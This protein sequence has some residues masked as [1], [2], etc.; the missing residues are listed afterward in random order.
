MCIRDRAY[1]E[2]SMIDLIL[3]NNKRLF[4]DV[5]SIP[6]VSG[7][8]DHRRVVRKLRM[9]M[10]KPFRCRRRKRFMVEK[11]RDQ[12]C[13][14]TFQR[15]MDTKRQ[16]IGE[17]VDVEEGWEVFRDTLVEVSERIIETKTIYGKKKRQTAWWIE[18]VQEAVKRKMKCF[19]RWMKTRRMEDREAYITVRNEI[20]VSYTHLTLPTSDLV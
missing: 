11:L 13:K 12:D 2:K 20:A 15:E 10:P 6:S 4:K 3:T 7:D 16:R 18:R 5:K 1:G 8:A 17:D 19:R 9:E 14:N